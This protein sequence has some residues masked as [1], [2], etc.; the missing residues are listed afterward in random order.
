[1]SWEGI[2]GNRKAATK[3]RSEQ[4]WEGV[5]TLFSALLVRESVW[6]LFRPGCAGIK[7]GRDGEWDV[8][9]RMLHVRWIGAAGLSSGL[10][11]I[12]QRVSE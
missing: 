7:R 5:G 9:D 1:M 8:Y 6:S 11:R 2:T 3:R 12:L 4:G 10:I